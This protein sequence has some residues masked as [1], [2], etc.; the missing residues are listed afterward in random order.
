MALQKQVKRLQQKLH[1]KENTYEPSVRNPSV[2]A[3]EAGSRT[4]RTPTRPS[5]P[6]DEQFCYRCGENGHFVAKCHNP[7]NQNKVIRKLIRALKTVKENQPVTDPTPSEVVCDVKR[8]VVNTP[9][10]TGIPEGLIGPLSLVKLKVNGHPCNALMDSGSQVTI[11]F[12]SWYKEHLA[13]V[14]VHPVS[15]LAIWGLSV[16]NSSY[17]YRGYSLVDL[18]YP[19][20]VTGISEVVTVLALICPSPRSEE[21]TPVIIGTN[22]CHVRN[23]VKRCSEKGLDITKTLGIQVHCENMPKPPT[24]AS[25]TID[26]DD[27]GCVT[28]QG[29][30]SLTLPPGQDLQVS[31]KVE[32][33]QEVDKEILMVDTSPSAPL[34]ASVLLQPM[35]VPGNAVNVNNFQILV[36]NQSLRETVIPEGTVIGH[37]YLTESVTT[38]S[39][40]KTTATDFDK[41]LINFGDSPVTEEWKERLRQKLSQ[42]SHVFSMEEWEVGEAKGVEHTIRLSDSRPFR[43][44]SRRLT[45]ADIDDVRKHLQELKRAGIIKESR[46]PYASPI[47]IV[48]K[49]NGSIRMCIDY[50]LLNSRT[51][52]D[53]YTTPCIDD[54]LDSLSGSKWFSVLDLRSGYYQIPMAEEDKEKNGVHLPAGV[55]PVRENAPGNNR[56]PSYFPKANGKDCG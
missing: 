20:D 49:K 35:V 54:A 32:F 18:E 42:C 6:S 7:E 36:Q 39:F 13:D 5:K 17:P 26:D 15:G 44:R 16:S 14:P 12:E 51:I 40:Q 1:K 45:P 30:G 48:R 8:S 27:V 9:V 11:I 31:C 38:V 56:S 34:P 29:P 52:P 19:A 4:P 46:S 37:L 23:L 43:Q 53:Q 28:W 2:S 25:P 21:Q 10:T 47:V 41:T 24:L 55:L 3:V 22:T 33:M 50:R